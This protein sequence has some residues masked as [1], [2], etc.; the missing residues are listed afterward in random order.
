MLRRSVSVL[1]ILLAC[2]AVL[3]PAMILMIESFTGEGGDSP[4][5]HDPWILTVETLAWS[6]G[7]AIGRAGGHLRGSVSVFP[8]RSTDNAHAH[9]R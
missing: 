8:E 5:M 1:V 3:W 9:G 2:I 6:I 7:I 4:L